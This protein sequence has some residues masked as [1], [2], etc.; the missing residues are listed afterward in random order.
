[1]EEETVV[2]SVKEN[3]QLSLEEFASIFEQVPKFEQRC[4]EDAQRLT[5]YMRMIGK[6]DRQIRKAFG[7]A[8]VRGPRKNKAPKKKGAP[9]AA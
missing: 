1:M 4:V 7:L 3:T 2:V 6:S 8:A 5:G 9:V